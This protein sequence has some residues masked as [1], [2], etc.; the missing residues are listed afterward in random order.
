MEPKSI[1]KRSKNE[2]QKMMRKGCQKGAQPLGAPSPPRRFPSEKGTNKQTKQQTIT[3][4]WRCSAN[5]GCQEKGAE[6]VPDPNTP[7]APKARS[8]SQ[9]PTAMYPLRALESCVPFKGKGAYGNLQW[10]CRFGCQQKNTISKAN[11]ENNTCFIRF[12]SKVHPK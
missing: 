7:R 6:H 4:S 10:L 1:K 3:E 5:V 8:G 9:L 12:S 2:V 11:Y